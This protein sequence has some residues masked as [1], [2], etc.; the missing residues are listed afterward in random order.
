[1]AIPKTFPK[2]ELNSLPQILPPSGGKISVGGAS[3]KVEDNPDGTHTA[4]VAVVLDDNDKIEDGYVRLKAKIP[5]DPSYEIRTEKAEFHASCYKDHQETQGCTPINKA[6]VAQLNTKLNRQAMISWI[7]GL[8]KIALARLTQHLRKIDKDFDGRISAT[9]GPQDVRRYDSDRNGHVELWEC[10][11]AAN[12]GR[13]GNPLFSNE[14]I[15]R[16]KEA[17]QI[18]AEAKL[19][20]FIFNHIEVILPLLEAGLTKKQAV[21]LITKITEN[22]FWAEIFKSLPGVVAALKDL[23]LGGEDILV[24]LKA[25]VEVGQFALFAYQELPAAARALRK[26][27]VEKEKKFSLLLEIATKG[28]RFVWEAY[29]R[30]PGLLEA[31]GKANF[32]ASEVVTL[33]TEIAGKAG[34]GTFVAYDHLSQ[35]TQAL[36]KLNLGKDK[37][38]SLLS[39]IIRNSK[40]HGPEAYRL[41]PDVLQALANLNQGANE[42]YSLLDQIAGKKEPARGYFA[43]PGAVAALKKLNR[44]EGEIY[45]FLF[46]I[47]A[48]E[49][50]SVAYISLPEAIETLGNL[51]RR[52]EETFEFLRKIA[53][54]GKGGTGFYY[55]SLPPAVKALQT[56]ELS[57]D[58]IL[59]LLSEILAKEGS[60]GG[61]AYHSLPGAIEALRK[62]NF[63][64]GRI[65]TLFREMSV[66]AGGYHYPALVAVE[67]LA[68]AG[69]TPRQTVTI[70]T[71]LAARAKWRTYD[72][73]LIAQPVEALSAKGLSHR[74]ISAFLIEIAS[75]RESIDKSYKLLTRLAEHAAW[76]GP[77][78]EP[79]LYQFKRG[80][81]YLLST[82]GHDVGYL[83]NIVEKGSLDPTTIKDK[84]SVGRAIAQAI[85][86]YYEKEDDEKKLEETS[87][88]IAILINDLHDRYPQDHDRLRRAICQNLTTR[89]LYLLTAM[90]GPDL[91]TT[92][93]LRLYEQMEVHF[94]LSVVLDDVKSIDPEGKYLAGFLLTLASFGRLWELLEEDPAYLGQ[95]LIGLIDVK[96]DKELLEN[97]S[98]LTSV[99]GEILQKRGLQDL[100]KALENHFLTSYQRAREGRNLV[101]QGVLGYLIKLYQDHFRFFSEEARRVA[102]GLP[103][104][105]TPKVP[106]GWLADKTLKAKLYFYEDE[107]SHFRLIQSM[108][109]AKGFQIRKTGERS[110]QM[111]KG[112]SGITLE[113]TAVLQ[114]V[115]VDS[116]IAEMMDDPTIDILAHRG[117]SFHLSYTFTDCDDCEGKEKLLY[118]GSCGS[119]RKVPALMESFQ[120]N[121]FVSDEDTGRGEDNNHILYYLMEAVAKGERDWDK[122]RKYVSDRHGI[123]DRGI[124]FPTDRSLLL[125]SF[126]QAVIRAR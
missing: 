5:L 35:A 41:L 65:V 72:A 92:S 4:H 14:L 56:I 38:L 75:R 101:Q 119:F 112:V 97:V 82:I 66:R 40:E 78:S 62:Q 96:E 33:L 52:S 93:F 11:I 98:L 54:K 55:V 20:L 110:I 108:Y 116:D 90:G 76:S 84:E 103:P 58:E 42:I 69:F 124:I 70:L 95:K 59:S 107:V 115:G 17:Y 31:L 122:I 102:Q 73:Y 46:Q 88:K 12:A 126:V 104:I 50:P 106:E 37:T 63:S 21:D 89:S 117:H 28:Q 1:M 111:T 45:S 6:Y 71:A 99:I 51:G 16:V 67:A 79:T 48:T 120:G 118:L 19:K 24:L 18:A 114:K 60:F 29:K 34:E 2:N 8:E 68:K 123:E 81:F 7:Q 125:F 85:N 44:G 25:M 39:K 86:Q 94:G 22:K 109:R 57:P 30:L 53:D 27:D 77:P 80:F 23:D 121:Y 9:E 49:E 13:K 64:K 15:S 36:E 100:K 43:L 91:Y 74:E 87:G 113:V 26:L 83:L 61:L 47:A 10:M 3:Y 105:L 32:G